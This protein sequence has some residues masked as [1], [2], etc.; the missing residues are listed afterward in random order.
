MFNFFKRKKK[1]LP[2]FE[3]LEA[4]SNKDKYFSRTLQYDWLNESMIH[5]F[6]HKSKSPRMITMDPWPQQVYLDADGTRTVK[7]YIEYMA[8]LY[9]NNHIPDQLD[10]EIIEVLEDLVV[11]GEI[12]QLTDSPVTLPYYLDRPKSKQDIDKAYQMM[13]DD[14]FAKK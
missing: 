2:V 7:E 5:L 1:P 6:D 11:D 3:H 4:Y 9:A 13:L 8:G 12:V 14:G 10:K